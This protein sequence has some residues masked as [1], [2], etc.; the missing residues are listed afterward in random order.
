MKKNRLL[1]FLCLFTAWIGAKAD[2][3]TIGSLDAASSDSYLPMNSLYEYS[4]TQQIYTAEEIGMAGTINSLTVWMHGNANLYE[5]PFDIYMVQLDKEAFSSTSDWVTVTAADLVYSG[6]VTVHN[7]SP[8]AFKFDLNT[9]FDYDGSSNLLICFNNKTGQWKSGLNGKVF[10]SSSDPKRSIYSRRDGDAYELNSLPQAT[11]TTHLRNVI[12][13]GI[14][15]GANSCER[16]ATLTVGDVLPH[17]ATLTWTEGTGI[18]N[19]EYKKAADEEWTSAA[20]EI[21]DYSYVLTGLEPE[22]EYQAHVQSV[23]D[24]ANASSWKMVSF[25]TPIACPAPTNLAV[26]LTPGDGTVASLRWTENGSASAWQICLND[27]TDNPIDADTNPF[28][29]TNLTPEATYTAKVRAIDGEEISKWSDPITFVPTDAYQITVNDGTTTNGYLPIYGYWVDNI[30]K[31]Q[32]II[33]STSLTSMAYGTIKKM[34]FY[35]GNA[36][37]N[38]GNAQFDVYVAEVGNTTFEDATLVDWS[39]MDKV[40]SAGSLSVSGNKMEVTLDNDYL[41]EGDNL[42][43]GFL[44][45]TSGSY[46]SVSWYGI[47]AAGASIGGYGNTISQQNFLPK[48]TF[49]Y[50]PGEIPTCARPTGLSV[51]YT[52]GVTADL[53]WIGDGL[54]DISL[55]G[56]IIEEVTNPYTLENLDL[57]TPYEVM[58]RSNCGGGDVSEWSKAVSFITDLCM[59]EDQ[60]VITLALTDSYGDGWNGNAIQV[61]DAATNKVLGEFANINLDGDS[62]KGV[63]QYFT[64][65]VCKDRELKFVWVKG[66]YASECSWVITDVNEEEILSGVGTNDLAGG[67]VLGTFTTDCVVTS[68]RRVTDLAVSEIQAR[69]VKLSWTENA[70]AD[71]WKI[72]IMEDEDE[73]FTIF[74]AEENPYTLTD[75]APNTHYTVKVTSDCEVDKWSEE[76]E[77]TTTEQYF[78][79]TQVTASDLKPGSATITWNGTADSYNLRYREVEPST[80][81]TVTLTVG[82][83][84]S[85]GSGYQMLLDVD[86]EAYGNIMP[87]SGPLTTA[88]DASDDVYGEFE[89]KIPEEADGSL[90]TSNIVINNS[91]SIQIPAGTYDWCI[92]N[93]T[94]GDRVWI[95]GTDGDIPGR[96]DDFEFEA[97]KNYVFT[98]SLNQ[99]TNHDQVNLTITEAFAPSEDAEES[100]WI[101]TVMDVE[102]PYVIEGLTEETSYEVQVQAVYGG[103]DPGESQWASAYFTTPSFCA[104]PKKLSAD[105]VFASTANVSWEGVQETFNVRWRT[106][107]YKETVF[108]E[109]FEA[110]SAGWTVDGGDNSDVY[111]GLPYTGQAMFAFAQYDEAQKIV[112]PELTDV[113]EGAKL[114]FYYRN[115]YT[116][117]P[118][119]EPI[120]FKVGYSADGNDYTWGDAVTLAVENMNAY[121]LYEQTLPAD[122]KYFAIQCTTALDAG[123]YLFIDDAS[124]FNNEHEAGEWQTAEGVTNPYQITGLNPDT[125][126]DWQVQGVS[127][128]CTDGVTEWSKTGTFTTELAVIVTIKDGFDGTTVASPYALDFSDTGLTVHKVTGTVG[129]KTV[130]ILTDELTEGIVPAEEGILVKGEPGV[131]Q[132]TVVENAENSFFSDNLLVGAVDGYAPTSDDVEAQTVYRYGKAGGKCG[133]QLVTK[134]SQTVGAGKAYLRLTE[135]LAQAA[136]SLGITFGDGETTGI[137]AISGDML[138][139]SAP[140]FNTAGQR[141]QKSY[142]GVVIQNG[143]KYI[144]K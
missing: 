60:C 54:Y 98:V 59:P 48:V 128:Y 133:F 122:V 112:S 129:T 5:M 8:E 63:P 90:S 106:S 35:S 109:D 87:T 51:E 66:S 125:M 116:N 22:T 12:T 103:E 77:F 115:Y 75:L 132:V 105:E 52:G 101:E 142:K 76:I 57:A 40:L 110:G 21:E 58:V 19:V 69:S 113:A 16:P 45:T 24:A 18:Y 34:T 124:I 29:L 135:A 78:K 93:P 68:C 43:I 7:S 72:G 107:A 33:P 89:Y 20:T 28:G 123:A 100:E 74:Y 47:T 138:D 50:E 73:E 114:N 55:N 39:T 44:Q 23:C 82:D 94:P 136:A 119:G 86:A 144:K 121:A 88:G 85:D 26:T 36:N 130:Y 31:G 17:G 117:T 70:E 13:L 46:N 14:T 41:Y 96:Y 42:M 71:A 9:P 79:P 141:V 126:Y 4:F 27:D 140:M 102:S 139:E 53:S 62:D 10:G 92:T 3:V 2:D 64:I 104:V 25:T 108:S 37:V 95:A 131:Y 83:V 49:D 118:S 84:W 56:E 99:E 32:F 137:D 65:N 91:V 15:P 61:V 30:T 120:S 81:A 38:W 1:L 134:T 11:S 127:N 80:M 67:A 6:S 143:K 97:G 111:T